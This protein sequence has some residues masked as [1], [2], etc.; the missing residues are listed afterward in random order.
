MFFVPITMD[1]KVN[2]LGTKIAF[3]CIMPLLL[4]G[5]FKNNCHFVQLSDIFLGSVSGED[6]VWQ[7]CCV[8]GM[9]TKMTNLSRYVQISRKGVLFSILLL[10]FAMSLMI[11]LFFIAALS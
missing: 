9:M 10:N 6:L 8:C 4:Q 3:F 5:N 7:P 2:M 1:V 11:M